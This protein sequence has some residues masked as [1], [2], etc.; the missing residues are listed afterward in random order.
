MD[1]QIKAIT[2]IRSIIESLR[3]TAGWLEA[4][5]TPPE[6][7]GMY[8][9][10]GYVK[11]QCRSPDQLRAAADWIG[12]PIAIDGAYFRAVREAGGIKVEAWANC[13]DVGEEEVIGITRYD[14]RNVPVKEWRLLPAETESVEATP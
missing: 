10:N 8:A 14:G 2:E 11:L 5:G 7:V 4:A 12:A 9:S 13:A 1:G 6:V 3:E